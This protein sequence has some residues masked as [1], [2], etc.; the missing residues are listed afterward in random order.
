MFG[1]HFREPTRNSIDLK[2]RGAILLAVLLVVSSACSTT[3]Y[4]LKPTA[5][6]V[7][8]VFYVSGIPAVSEI[9]YY[10]EDEFLY[11]GVRG[12]TNS[13]LLVLQLYVANETHDS[14]D[15][16]PD[17]IEVL[18]S[19][20]DLWTALRVWDAFDYIR[21]VEAQQATA[22]VIDAIASGLESANA[23]RSTT[24]QTGLYSDAYGQPLGS[25]SGSSTTYDY[26][27]VAEAQSR[28]AAERRAMLDSQRSRL[29]LL[30]VHLLKR[31]TLLP[32]H[33]VFGLVFIERELY[34]R[35]RIRVPIDDRQVEVAFT[36]TEL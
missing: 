7:Q 18:G 22:R 11:I 3:Q 20:G 32:G 2:A 17:E 26:S 6:D 36:L 25:Y 12:H 9:L 21:H 35:Y 24:Q 30:D 34:D 5:S 28:N 33:D 4:Y 31:T 8:D 23:G 29:S 14:L 10:D 1:R 15:V 13:E 27:R 16:L 19:S